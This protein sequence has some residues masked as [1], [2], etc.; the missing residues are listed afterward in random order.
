MDQKNKKNKIEEI[1]NHLSVVDLQHFII[2]YSAKNSGFEKVFID[3]FNLQKPIEEK[4]EYIADIQDAFMG[5]KSQGRNRHQDYG[6][7]GFD[8]IEVAG[9]LE[10]ILEKAEYYIKHG[11]YDEAIVICKALIETI[12]D[13]W[14]SDSDYDGDVQVIYD[15]AIDKLHLLLEQKM[16]SA[17][18]KKE[19][20]RWYNSE[21]KNEKHEY[22]GLNTDL[23]VLE[24]FFTDTPEMLQQNIANMEERI[25]NSERDYDRQHAVI[26]KISLLQ[27][28]GRKDE[29]EDAI[30]QYIHFADVRK[31]RLQKLV[32][33]KNYKEAI[34]IIEGGLKVAQQQNHAGTLADWKDELLNIYLLQNDTGKIIAVAE[35]LFVNGRDSRKYYPIL[36]QHITPDEWPS[37]LP[38]L[39]KGLADYDVLKAEILIDH[40]MWKELFDLCKKIN[41]ESIEAYEKHLKPHFAK[42]I[43][44]EYHKYVEKQALITD[45]VA[46][47]NVARVL[48]KMKKYEGGVELVQRLVQKYRMTYKRRKNMLVALEDI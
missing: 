31:L 5:S 19:L 41:T 17:E 44:D 8:A 10:P 40:S 35:D 27:H 3:S 4:E 1:L 29:A 34:I 20:F 33:E 13:E 26:A 32:D 6:D 14:D 47:R 42:E 28:A 7:Y 38:R 9:D 24:R 12:P 25:K 48:V 18:Q 45:H 21:H 39:L 36:K 22:V 23:K 37:V 2:A 11:N 16:L 43:F 30:S 15:Q 46:Y